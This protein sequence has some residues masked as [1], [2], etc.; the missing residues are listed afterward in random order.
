VTYYELLGVAPSAPLDQVRQAYHAAI[1]RY[2]PDVNKAP[3][4]SVLTMQLNTAWQTLRDPKSRSAYDR[5][6]APRP[7]Y[8]SQ[9]QSRQTQAQAPPPHRTQQRPQ[10]QPPPY[11]AQQQAPPYYRRHAQP[12]P[13]PPEYEAWERRWREQR[14]MQQTYGSPFGG[15]VSTVVRFAL[16]FAFVATVIHWFPLIAMICVALVVMR[17]A[18]RMLT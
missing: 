16:L 6:I 1:R 17:V 4:A 2:H 10:A 18:G 7:S 12:P 11:R 8:Q 13:P 3:N 5:A 14:Y 9:T 15:G